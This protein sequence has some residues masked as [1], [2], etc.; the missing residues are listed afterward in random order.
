MI[1]IE[2]ALSGPYR[3]YLDRPRPRSER[4]EILHLATPL[5]G[6][7][8]GLLATF[9]VRLYRALTIRGCRLMT[10]G[11]VLFLPRL[12]I[13]TSLK[14]TRNLLSEISREALAEYENPKGP[15]NAD[16]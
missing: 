7:P 9:D 12:G 2:T 8:K 16:D 13:G 10:T 5:G 3:A 6:D 15:T 14:M 4:V 11:R 1:R